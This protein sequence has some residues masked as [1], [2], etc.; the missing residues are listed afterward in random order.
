MV[1]IRLTRRG[2]K[3]QPFYHVVV[4]DSRKRQGGASL[5]RVG[6]FNP[7]ARGKDTRCKLDLERIDTGARAARRSP[8]ACVRWLRAIAGASQDARPGSRLSRY[9][10]LGR[11]VG[12]HGVRGWVRVQLLHRSARVAAAATARGCCAWADGGERRVE[13]AAG[14]MGRRMRCA[15]RSTVSPT[16]MRRSALREREVLIERAALPAAGAA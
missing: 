13:R 10:V 3:N 2:A 8:I 4:T 6:Y 11:I 12:A 16:G 15:S 14:A 5:E 9:L 1:T 7:V